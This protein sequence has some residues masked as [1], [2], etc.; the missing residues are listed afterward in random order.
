VRVIAHHKKTAKK[1]CW[2]DGISGVFSCSSFMKY[3]FSGYFFVLITTAEQLQK[4]SRNF[5][6]LIFPGI[7]GSTLR[8]YAA[9]LIFTSY[10]GY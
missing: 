7:S 5:P 3:D 10:F 1:M 4:V 6:A 2:Q 8:F 9:S